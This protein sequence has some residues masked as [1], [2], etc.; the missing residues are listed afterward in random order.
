MEDRTRG[1]FVLIG[2]GAAKATESVEACDL[3]TSSYFA[4]KR[5]YAVQDP[6]GRFISQIPD[7]NESP[8]DLRPI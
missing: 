7:K 5:Q 3:Y 2:C 4:V 1:R 8:A 6:T